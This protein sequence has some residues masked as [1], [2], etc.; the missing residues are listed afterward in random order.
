MSQPTI[1]VPITSLVE[2]DVVRTQVGDLTV[3][4]ATPSRTLRDGVRLETVAARGNGIAWD[5]H[6]E[7]GIDLVVPTSYAGCDPRG[8]CH[9][10]ASH[11]TATCYGAH[12]AHTDEGEG[13]ALPFSVW[14][15]A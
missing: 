15:R 7:A 8:F 2:G 12:R 11:T 3:L 13:P 1:L 9:A 6:A 4:S 14:A 5:A 10:E